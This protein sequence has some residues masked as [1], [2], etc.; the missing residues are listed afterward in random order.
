MKNIGKGK[1]IEDPF[2]FSSIPADPFS[3]VLEHVSV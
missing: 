2:R 3:T 1:R